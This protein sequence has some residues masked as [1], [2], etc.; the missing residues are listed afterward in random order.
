VVTGNRESGV[1]VPLMLVGVFV[2]VLVFVLGVFAYYRLYNT[3]A[4]FGSTTLAWN[5]GK[6]NPMFRS[7][8][9]TIRHHLSKKVKV[10]LLYPPDCQPFIKAMRAFRNILKENMHVQVKKKIFYLQ[11]S[12]NCKCQNSEYLAPNSCNKLWLFSDLLFSSF[13]FL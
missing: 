1:L 4:L 10:L 3:R 12:V 7:E 11:S 13:H 8:G 6:Y 2:I 5:K 9:Q